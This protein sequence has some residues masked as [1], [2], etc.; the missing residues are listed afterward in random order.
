[1][2]PEEVIARNVPEGWTATPVPVPAHDP[3]AAAR[4]L[5]LCESDEC[6]CYGRSWACPPGWTDRMDVLGGRYSGA[7]L[8]ERTFDVSPW[9]REALAGASESVH[10]GLRALVAALRSEGVPAL[11]LTDG[12]CGYCGVCSY[13]EP[14]RF[15]EQLTPSISAAGIDMGALLGSIGRKFEFRDDRV[16]LYSLVLYGSP[17]G[18][19]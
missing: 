4:F 15:P 19:P 17:A 3:E 16:T 1:M 5:A 10:R 9:D 11:G 18:A 13:P 2:D 6:G 14:C 7:V 8:L 12:A